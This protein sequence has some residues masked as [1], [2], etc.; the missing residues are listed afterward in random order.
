MKMEMPLCFLAF[1]SVA[2]GQP[3]VVGVGGA[4]GEHLLA[5]DDVVVA[6]ADRGGA[7]R[8]QVA[9]GLRLGV[10][11]GE[12]D[13][14][15]QDCG[16]EGLLLLVGA[17]LHQ[18]RP[19]GVQSHQR[20]RCV[21]PPCLF[22][23]DELLDGREASP[24]KLFGPT[25]TEQVCIRQGAH[26]FAHRGPA[27][28]PFADGGPPLRRH[29]LFHR[30]ADLVA[31]PLLLVGVVEAHRSGSQPYRHPLDAGN[32]GGPHPVDRADQFDA[33]ETT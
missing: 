33:G 15:V 2:R 16:Q 9:A 25:D 8:R 23:E 12:L 20:D 10:S 26:T 31:Q 19:D 1:G 6:V 32:H 18:R 22:G 7:Q 21:D 14:A 17:V 30:R 27:L 13:A 24:A 4:A 29:D 3:D 28:D 5:V 11:D